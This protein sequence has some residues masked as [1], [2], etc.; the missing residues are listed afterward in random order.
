MGNF[1]CF[2]VQELAE[3]AHV[4]HTN[5]TARLQARPAIHKSTQ[6]PDLSGAAQALHKDGDVPHAQ[7]AGLGPRLPI[8]LS[9]QKP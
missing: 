5:P 3:R 6:L 2:K 8:A 1:F 4:H 9:A 7:P